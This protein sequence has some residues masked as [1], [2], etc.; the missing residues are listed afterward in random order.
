MTELYKFYRDRVYAC[1]YYGFRAGHELLS[2]IMRTAFYDSALTKAEFISIMNLCQ[3]AHI[4][5]MEDNYNE[6]WQ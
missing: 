2:V 6:G 4:E 3:Q 5:M 1:P